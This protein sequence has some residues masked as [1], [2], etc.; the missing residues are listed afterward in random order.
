MKL[1]RRHFLQM[2]IA[3]SAA[4]YFPAMARTP[5]VF[6]VTYPGSIDDSFLEVVGAEFKRVSGGSVITTPMMNMDLIGRLQ[7][8][9]SNPPFDVSL[10]DDG[11]L[12]GAIQDDLLE[13]FPMAQS[14]FAGD[15][16]QEYL[17]PD[18][19]A[20]AVSNSMIGIAYNPS[21]VDKPT[22]WNDLFS[23]EVAGSVGIVGPASTLGTTFLIELGRMFGGSETD[24]EPAF[25]ALERLLPSVGAIGASPG[26]LT[27]LMQQGEVDIA[28]N[29][30]NNVTA[31]K[32]QGMDVEFA[33]PKEGLILQRITLQLI[34]NARNREHALQLIDIML[35]PKIQAQLEAAPWNMVPTHPDV[36]LTGILSAYGDNVDD[37]LAQGRFLDWSQFVD[38]RSGWV[39][40]FD[41]V[42]RG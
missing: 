5:E 15:L 25:E 40:R 41:R 17:H 33:V 28:P 8:S 20:P 42:V 11:P 24:V 36:P 6:A 26:A 18:G 14:R 13:K 7:A 2:T 39:E 4:A 31:L 12:I 21:R 10:F 22:S 35:D 3:A 23:P 38:L 9:R 37:L 34:K 27:T 29:F 16:A 30:F 32:A 1:N 19:Y